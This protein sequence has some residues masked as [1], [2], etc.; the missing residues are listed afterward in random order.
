MARRVTSQTLFGRAAQ[1]EALQTSVAATADGASRIV[2]LAGDA[3]IGKTRLVR[4]TVEH[5]R[6]HGVSAAVGG[7]VQ[8]GE[9][10][11]AFAPL[12]EALRDLRDQLGDAELDELLGTGRPQLR[13]LL[14]GDDPPGAATG[15][16]FEHLLGFLNRLGARQPALLVLEDLH[17]A[18]A[19]TRDLVAYLGRNL[20][21]AAVTLVLTLR[22]DEL[23][24]RHP[25]RPIVA[26]LERSDRV[27]RI[28]IGGLERADVARLLAEV[29]A[30]EVDESVIDDL[31]A[32]SGGNPFYVEEL[33]AAGRLGG[34]LPETL[35]EV[36][37]GRIEVLSEDARRMLRAAAVIDDHVDD[38][39]VAAVTGEPLAEVTAALREAVLEQ[40]LVLDASTC[41][42]RH[43]LVRE[44]LYDDLLPGERTRLHV[45]TATVLEHADHLPPHTRWAM[46]AYHWDAARDAPKAFEASV[47][48][49]LEAEHVHALA[50]AAEQ[51]ERALGLREL[52]ADPDNRAGMTH[53][54]LLLR[55]ADAVQATS[56]TNRAVVLAEAALR[57]LGDGATPEQCALVYE[58]LG[59]ANWT[60]HRGATA[61]QAYEHGAA[62]V[63]DRP[64]SRDKAY[65]LSA[66]GQSL[67]VRALYR[68][69]IPILRE[70]IDVAIETGATD[71]EGHA[72]C[73][74]GP[75]LLGVGRTDE[76]F[77]EMT[78]ALE[79]SLAAD[80]AEDVSRAYTNL[81]HC[82][83][84]GARYAQITDVARDGLDYVVRIGHARHYGEAIAGN[85]ISALYCAGEWAE[86]ERVHDD[87]RIP[88]GDPYQEL[89][90]LPV[91]LDSGRYDEARDAVRATL[92]S[93]AEADD[94]QFGAA[95]LLL[96][97][98]LGVVDGH[99]DD[100][101]RLVAGA[102]QLIERTDDQFYL[103]MAYA[104]GLA[105]EAARIEALPRDDIGTAE[106]RAVAD[107]LHKRMRGA[108]ADLADRATAV[109]PEPAAWFATGEVEHERAWGANDPARW[110][111][112]AQA[113]HAAGQP[114][115]E[116][117]AALRQADALVRS[118]GDRNTAAD[119]VRGALAIAE[120]LGARP[121]EA[122]LRGLAR[123]AR[124]DIAAG[125]TQ[126]DGAQAL[127]VTP[128]ELDVL[129][130]VA[131]G[132]TNRQIGEALFISEKT[133]SV[134]VTN[135]LRKLGV[136]SRVEAAAVA[137]RT[138]LADDPS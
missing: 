11:I 100:A 116:A 103:A 86:A 6:A 90:W 47:Q 97:A 53:A 19:S 128:R 1:I 18:D 101:R 27:E 46:L 94:V 117:S 134:H 112:V 85:V 21:H 43:A 98:R 136:A 95:A 4:E 7:C 17:W 8:L 127:D 28:D 84:N 107:D 118:G 33:V 110:A 66:L 57:V 54:A 60:L 75:C 64:P 80:N 38:E 131:Q 91:L 58:R 45:A 72:R 37:L 70:A 49:G 83:H 81:G 77:A 129:R 73:S 124:L 24:R 99:W 123:R 92:A 36:I 102:L 22:A 52:V 74:L 2:L 34:G 39:L 13:A 82:C 42:F 63:V 14:S 65:I 40:V 62:L 76:A 106:A 23:H 113:W 88:N 67:M 5:A 16:L 108:L 61:V 12:V 56:R 105:I 55:A 114:M 126:R 68:Q 79:L 48:A 93:T 87:A 31:H 130:L 96:A 69:A 132:R 20:R 50:D 32:R 44:A 119:L 138:G 71:V 137:V 3:G 35:A 111:D 51:Y 120:R 122:E 29:G 59:R 121:L 15:A 104:L 41:R 30:D 25:L 133:A 9:V 78:R 125:H 135:L 89:R 109:L 26:A 115:H 10:S